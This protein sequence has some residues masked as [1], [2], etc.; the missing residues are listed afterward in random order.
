[1]NFSKDADSI[2]TFESPWIHRGWTPA[3]IYLFL[4]VLGLC[5]CADF[6]LVTASRGYSL[7]LVSMGF[8][9]RWLLL[10]QNTTRASGL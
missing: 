1:M 8:S 9:L 3:F 6:S 2:P 7:I 10:L 4:T 5:C